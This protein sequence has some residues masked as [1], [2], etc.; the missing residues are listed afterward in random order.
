MGS[1]TQGHSGSGG[2]IVDPEGDPGQDGDQD[3][4]HVGLE[5]KVADVPL[6]LEAQRQTWVGTCMEE[7][8][9]NF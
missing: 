4:G 3:R 8:R 1:L 2:I 9:Q 7:N 6:Q 5:D